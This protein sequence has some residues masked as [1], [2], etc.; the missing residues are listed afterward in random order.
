M[1][2]LDSTGRSNADI[3][4]FNKVVKDPS[5]SITTLATII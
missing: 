2:N 1:A 4:N 3:L 5:I